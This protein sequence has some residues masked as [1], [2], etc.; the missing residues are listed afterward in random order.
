M[1]VCW[2]HGEDLMKGDL[3]HRDALVLQKSGNCDI[4]DAFIWSMFVAMGKLRTDI[5]TAIPNLPT[6]RK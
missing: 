4:F 5:P 2:E 1:G 6:S 3:R